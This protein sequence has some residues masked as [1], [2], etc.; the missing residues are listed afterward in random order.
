MSPTAAAALVTQ[1]HVLSKLSRYV[2]HRKESSRQ[3]VATLLTKWNKTKL[4]EFPFWDIKS[5]TNAWCWRHYL[6]F[7]NVE[8]IENVEY[9][10]LH[11]GGGE[12]QWLICFDRQSISVDREPPGLLF[13]TLSQVSLYNYRKGLC[14]RQI[15]FFAWL[16]NVVRFPE[17]LKQFCSCVC[18]A[19]FAP[20]NISQFAFFVYLVYCC[21]SQDFLTVPRV[22]SADCIDEC[23]CTCVRC[24]W[25]VIMGS[26][27]P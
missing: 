26:L 1:V 3:N 25:P 16:T 24:T 13:F 10:P 12:G 22:L 4:N 14:L 19:W 2:F 27:M 6:S 23:P 5:K 18:K 9:R 15:V 17:C 11:W 20:F 7:V 8:V 21:I